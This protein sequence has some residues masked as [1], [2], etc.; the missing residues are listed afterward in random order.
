MLERLKTL[1]LSTEDFR[2]IEFDGEDF[3]ELLAL[4][5][6]AQNPKYHPEGDA[7]THTILVM[8][9][10]ARLR[11][12]AWSPFAFMLAALCHDYGKAVCTAKKDGKIVSYGHEKSGVPL[13]QSFMERFGVDQETRRLV[14]N[15][16][17]YHMRP[18]G[19]YL[20]NSSEKATRRLFKKSLCPEDLLLLAKADSSGRGMGGPMRNYGDNE[21]WLRERLE[22]FHRWQNENEIQRTD[23]PVS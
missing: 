11:T 1:L 8:N 6:I 18:N 13:A 21:Q 12:Q 22:D 23:Q 2:E 17:E 9:Q 20:Q 7:F 4:R 5:G 19:L 14:L 3:R 16:V 10:A 15:H